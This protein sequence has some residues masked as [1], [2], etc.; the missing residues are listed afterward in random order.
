MITNFVGET[1][2]LSGEGEGGEG[3][4]ADVAGNVGQ[5]VGVEEG[6]GAD[7]ERDI[8]RTFSAAHRAEW[9]LA[10]N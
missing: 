1:G 3:G 7:A 10:N 8:K 9:G 6:D 2:D 5:G 4:A